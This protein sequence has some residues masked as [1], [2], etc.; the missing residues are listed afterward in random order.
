M[1]S[2]LWCH[3]TMLLRAYGC[4]LL[5]LI[6]MTGAAAQVQL[7]ADRELS[8]ERQERLLQEQQRRLEDLQ[9]LPGRQ[10]SAP[11]LPADDSSACLQVDS[12]E[13]NGA[14]ILSLRRRTRPEHVNLI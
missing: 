3:K 12:I 1:V 7:P 5:F 6:Y 10:L 14:D 4:A 8:R 13:L 2:S 9:S 11:S